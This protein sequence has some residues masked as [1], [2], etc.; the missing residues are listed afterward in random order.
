[1]AYELQQ[2]PVK[3]VG[4]S[5][6]GLYPKISAEKTFNM[7]ISDGWLVNYAGYRRINGQIDGSEGRALFHSIRGNFLIVVVDDKVYEVNSA[8]G[9]QQ[10]GT[11]STRV[12]EVFIDENLTSQICIVDGND[13]WIYN[14]TASTFTKQTL[15]VP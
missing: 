1:M 4:S 7:F 6:F 14:Y 10:I 8:L 5:T 3:V 12:G 9:A 2:V 11:L 15:T 13:A